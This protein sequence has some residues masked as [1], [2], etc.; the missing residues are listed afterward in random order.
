VPVLSLNL[1]SRS[2]FGQETLLED[3][4]K[5][6][7]REPIEESTSRLVGTL[8]MTW[9]QNLSAESE[10]YVFCYAVSWTAPSPN[11]EKQHNQL[12]LGIHFSVLLLIISQVLI[13]PLPE[14]VARPE[15]F[16]NVVCSLRNPIAALYLGTATALYHIPGDH[17]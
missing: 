6:H 5:S 15:C 4:Y 7:S 11:Q 13:I 2:N 9:P 10:C 17:L 16:Q 8:W 14:E 12:I 3:T 1:T